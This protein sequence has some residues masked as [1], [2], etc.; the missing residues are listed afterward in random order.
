MAALNVNSDAYEKTR[1]EHGRSDPG[2]HNEDVERHAL[3]LRGKTL[4]ASLA[5]VAGA[6]FTLFG[7]VSDWKHGPYRV[8]E[9]IGYLPVGMIKA[10]CRHC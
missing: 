2:L 10:L 9:L 4:T 8:L 7:Y 1:T 3:S 5:F 6:G